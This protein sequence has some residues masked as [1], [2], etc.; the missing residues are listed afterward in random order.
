[1][2]KPRSSRLFLFLFFTFLKKHNSLFLKKELRILTAKTIG[3]YIN[4]LSFFNPKKALKISYGLFSQP[5]KGRISKDKI[6]TILQNTQRRMV[7][8]LEHEF[9]TYTWVGND[10]VILLVHGWES[11]S[12]RWKKTL[13][14]LLKSGSTIIAIDAPAHGQSSGLEFNVPQYATFINKVVEEHK[15]SIIIGHSIGG[16]ASVYH[17][18]LF[19]ETSIQKMVILGSPSDLKTLLKN[20]AKLLSL[21]KKVFTLLEGYYLKYFNF[22][23]EDFSGKKFA[24]TITIKGIIAHDTTDKVVAFEEGKKIASTWKNAR[25][26]TT[27]GLGHGMHDDNLYDQITNF[28]FIE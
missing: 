2:E 11:N 7:K 28:L 10:T 5:R 8:H 26:I 27:T 6:P 21:N 23:I 17:Q 3:L 13:P 16:I 20:Y 1:M 15:P 19:P 4:V 22:N 12:S 14:H 24:S 25:F 9:Q 18:Y